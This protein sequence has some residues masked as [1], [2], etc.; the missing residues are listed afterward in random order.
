MKLLFLVPLVASFSIAARADMVIVQK[1][2]S[3]GQSA[4]MT[5]KFKGNKVRA[6]VSPQLTTLTDAAT[7]EV[8]TIMHPQK[9][10]MSI[11][12]SST[13]AMMEQMQARTQG[14][15]GSPAPHPKLQPTGR[16][17]KING[18]DTAEYVCDFG[19]MKIS[20]WLAPGFPNWSG[21]L[22]A[23]M[24]FQQGGLAA[25][26][27]AFMPDPSDFAGMPIRTETAMNGQKVTTT[28]VSVK[29]Q[30]VDESEFKIPAGY[31]ET[32]MPSFNAPPQP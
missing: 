24:K 32:K 18:F 10:Y 5:M 29:D 31:T 26:A 9:T 3:A 23:I 2:E 25:M 17:E 30:P 14:A 19:G 15:A 8:T 7:G 28:L 16:K 6:D 12:A 13:K 22:A 1:V 21:V 4:E 27:K 11:P 20:Y